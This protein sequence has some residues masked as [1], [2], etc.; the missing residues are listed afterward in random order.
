MV[1]REY[2]K[3]GQLQLYLYL[4]I[5]LLIPEMV[6]GQLYPAK[7]YSISDGLPSNAVYDATQDNRGVMWF[8]TSKG[9]S[10]YNAHT[11]QV[12]S[13]SLGLPTYINSKIRKDASGRIWVVGKNKERFVIKYY[14]QESWNQIPMPKSWPE[15]RLS[16][17]FEI[18]ERAGKF[19][20]L[21]SHRKTVFSYK[22]GDTAW[23]SVSVEG[24]EALR[25]HSIQSLDS[26]IYVNTSNGQFIYNEGQLQ[27]SHYT[28]AL[29]QKDNI[30]I[31]SRHNNQTYILGRS[32]LGRIVDGD[33]EILLNNNGI[34]RDSPFNR[35][36]LVI[37]ERYRVFYS[38]ASPVMMYKLKTGDQQKLAVQ[39]RKNNTHSNRIYL[40]RENNIW[41][42]D[43]RGLFKFNVLNI[44]HYNKEAGL[45]GD[46]VSAL[47]EGSDGRF[48]IANNM[49]LNVMYKGEITKQYKIPSTAPETSV[50]IL[51]LVQDP[52]GILYIAAGR[53]G[54][55]VYKKGRIEPA[56]DPVKNK[57]Q[58]VNSVVKYQSDILFS[59]G[60][61]IYKITDGGYRTYI[62][63]T[64][65]NIRNMVNIDGKLA[66][67]TAVE[68]VYIWDDG[69][70]QHFGADNL[71]FNNSYKLAKWQNEY[72][73]ATSGG[74][75][76]LKDEK[77]KPYRIKGFDDAVFSVMVDSENDLWIGTFNGVYKW[78][79]EDLRH[80]S[81]E[82]GL[83]GN[84]VN[85]N[86]FF[87]DSEGYIWIG[88]E[89]GVNILDKNEELGKK[90]PDLKLEAVSTYAFSDWLSKD[91]PGIRYD[92]NTVHFDF[93]AISYLYNDNIIYRYKLEGVEKDWNY[94][95]NYS[96]TSA[97]YR[98]LES[99]EY[100]FMIQ[101]RNDVSEWSSPQ[102]YS[103]VILKPIY[104]QWWFILLMFFISSIL[105][106]L[107]FR[108]R[109]FYLISK[110]KRL[111]EMVEKRTK[112][113]RE[114]NQQ[115]KQKNHSLEEVNEK[116]KVQTDSLNKA[117]QKLENA[118]VELIQKEK[119]AALG[120]L[121]AG[122]AHEINNPVNYIKS[123]SD[124]I[125]T[126]ID[127]EDD[128]IVI[129]EKEVFKEVYGSID[130]GVTKIVDIVRSLSS[131]SRTNE[132]DNSECDIH[133]ILDECLVILHHEYKNRVEIKKNY[134]VGGLEAKG[135]TG[136]LYQ[137]FTNI[138]SNAIQAIKEEGVIEIST[139]AS[140]DKAIIEIS[141][142]GKGIEEE[143]LTKIFDP[144]YTTKEPGQGTGLGLSIV[145]N[146]IQDHGGDIIY[147]SVPGSGTKVTV[148]LPCQTLEE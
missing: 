126:M 79:G 20:F 142:N 92:D 60:S 112:S 49:H 125:D 46:E 94:T 95:N 77:I 27:E 53:G 40:D 75:G 82:K 73:V 88:T 36:S 72:I 91:N 68:G 8:V 147:D 141:D 129:K 123:A 42:V 31:M 87:R 17:S 115:I 81:E 22:E 80:Y 71:M 128:K 135:N 84:E 11:W 76:I 97:T 96:A 105:I 116:L 113:I 85:R 136:K 24:N 28:A 6:F 59:D 58:L 143:V 83:I 106:Y 111:E 44:R 4:F 3:E 140:K 102:T 133:E 48:Y 56:I 34:Q 130:I 64:F 86:A 132:K 51:D 108:F 5:L 124:I 66:I 41:S 134:K 120:V 23:D 144:F 50:R 117:L 90:T 107:T 38:S 118:Q 7:V 16:F 10:T 30:L 137:V 99:N 13:D 122:V 47:Y 114:K 61:H 119:M 89:L 12:F 43:N 121:T 78:S 18:T 33:L 101:A 62:E 127:E 148:E 19:N 2:F 100:T 55:F 57:N 103:F 104:Q 67:L 145:Y 29:G 131:F 39:G 63:H 139:A 21:L 25:I 138:L 110:Q 15:E 146:I 69:K 26:T 37:D 93:L 65:N 1:V 70:L 98:N 14:A 35:H 52:S 45:A 74:L 9:V 54:L 32:W 109:Y